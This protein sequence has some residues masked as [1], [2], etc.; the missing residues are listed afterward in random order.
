VACCCDEC[1]ELAT[2]NGKAPDG[3]RLGNR[4]PHLILASSSY[5]LLRQRAHCKA[6]CWNNDH[7]GA[8]GAILERFTSAGLKAALF[9]HSDF[10]L[11][12]VAALRCSVASSDRP[13]N[14]QAHHRCRR[15]AQVPDSGDLSPRLLRTRRQWPANCRSAEQSDE[16]APQ[17]VTHESSL[18]AIPKDYHFA[19]GGE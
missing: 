17:H 2:R 18:C 1:R 16:C 11:N 19:I 15:D 13:N 14:G 12:A 8:A 5:F 7:V 6:S 10:D 3:K 4:H 9:T